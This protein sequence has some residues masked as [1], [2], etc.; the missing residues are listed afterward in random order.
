[1]Q[2]LTPGECSP[3]GARLSIFQRVGATESTFSLH[4][5]FAIFQAYS[6]IAN[7]AS[8]SD[9]VSEADRAKMQIVHELLNGL[10]TNYYEVV[11]YS[12]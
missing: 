4:Q 10:I 6:K 5:G 3:A 9:V 1:M 8:E 11:S 2:I 12:K 7:F